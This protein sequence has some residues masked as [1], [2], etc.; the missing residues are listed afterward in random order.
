[1]F[2]ALAAKSRDSLHLIDST[3]VKAHRAAAGAKG[4]RKIK[5]LASAAAG[6][7]R[8]ST[9]TLMARCGG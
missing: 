5:R 1:M 6:G 3:I 8:R 7:A 2:E 9:P 4:G